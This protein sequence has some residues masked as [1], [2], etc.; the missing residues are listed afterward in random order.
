MQESLLDIEYQYIDKKK[1]FE[2]QIKT[3]MAQ[4]FAGIQLWEQN[5]TLISPMMV[6]QRYF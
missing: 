4:L 1:T 5:Y 3:Y 6:Q 2:T